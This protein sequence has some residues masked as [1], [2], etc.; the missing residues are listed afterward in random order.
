MPHKQSF[1]CLSKITS[2]ILWIQMA[3]V[4]LSQYPVLL[5]IQYKVMFRRKVMWSRGPHRPVAWNRVC[6]G[7]NNNQL[8]PS[9][10][11]HSFPTHTIQR[12]ELKSSF[13]FMTGRRVS[14]TEKLALYF[15]IF[16]D[17]FHFSYTKTHPF[18]VSFWRF[19]TSCVQ[20][21]CTCTVCLQV[22]FQKSFPV[23]PLLSTEE[24]SLKTV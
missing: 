19:L 14:Q 3:C 1:Y 21:L 18:G 11:A 12:W 22:H 8:D 5:E 24:L 17:S 16:Y 20:L 10:V 15:Y 9:L 6:S 7:V 13:N 23:F 2:I 4:Q